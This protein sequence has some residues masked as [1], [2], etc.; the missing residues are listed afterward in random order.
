MPPKKKTVQNNAPVTQ[1]TTQ[2]RTEKRKAR[3]QKRRANQLT[4]GMNQMSLYPGV[5]DT[6]LRRL[7][8]KSR[9]PGLTDQGIAFLKCAF[10]PPDFQS[11]SVNGVPDDFRGPSLTRKHRFTGSGTFAANTDYYFLLAPIPGVAYFSCVVPAGSAIMANTGF[12]PSFYAD[13]GQMFPSPAQNTSVVTKFRYISNHFEIIP[14]TNQMTWS[15]QIQAWKIPLTIVARPSS[16]ANNADMY[17]IQGLEGCN[18]NLA[19]Q[20]TT[21]FING[22]YTACYSS[23]PEFSFKP[24]LDNV[25]NVPSTLGSSDFGFLAYN[26]ATPNSYGCPGIDTGF[27]TMLIKISGVTAAETAIFK[28]WTCIEYQVQPNSSLYEFQSLSSSDKLAM[29]LYREIILDLPIGVT[30]EQNES[31]WTRVLH[32]IAGITGLAANL[33]GGY[34]MAAR[35]TNLLANSALSFLS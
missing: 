3:R 8:T 32:I 35:G 12:V 11:S 17:S 14:T 6:G 28:T 4:S 27:E 5:S 24:I 19:N 7:R 13:S 25:T 2:K 18:T 34:G 22:V 29:E 23:D 1:T 33:P 20:F 21:P 10:A 15:G 26:A 30:F 31:F 16:A 9:R